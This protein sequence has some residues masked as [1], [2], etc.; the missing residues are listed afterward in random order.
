M[1][2]RVL[3]KKNWERSSYVVSSKAFFDA[4]EKKTNL[5]RRGLAESI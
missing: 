5:T 2:G 1:M 3:K 4:G